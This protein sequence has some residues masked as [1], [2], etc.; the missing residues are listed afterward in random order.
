MDKEL[1]KDYIASFQRRK[2]ENI[3]ER[4]LKIKIIKDKDATIISRR[5]C[6]KTFFIFQQISRFKRDEILYPNLKSLF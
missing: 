5:R 1:I 3:I 4:E 6:G 2:F